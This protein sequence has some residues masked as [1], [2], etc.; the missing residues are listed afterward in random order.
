[1]DLGPNT[2]VY[3]AR[4]AWSKDGKALYVQRQS[5]DQKRLDLLA[6][7]PATG[8][9]RVVLTETSPHWVELN[10]DFKPLQNGQFLWA[11]ER[12]GNNHLYL[13]EADGRLARQVTSGDWPVGD[14]A[15]V[16]EA[17]GLVLFTA[18]KD[19]P[20]E[21]QLYSTS[22]KEPGEPKALTS[23]HGSWSVTVAERGGAFTGTYSDPATPPRTGL[24]AA[25]GSLI[26]W[27]EP[28]KLDA[29]HPYFKYLDHHRTPEFGTIKASDGQTLHYSILTPPDFD[30]TKT[31]PVVVNVYGGPNVGGLVGR[32]WESLEDQLMVDQGYVLFKLDNR[33]T[34]GRSVAFKTAIYHHLG[35]VEVED[36]LAGV[37]FLK[38]LPYVDPSRI[39]IT[40]WSYGG[41]MTLSLM[42]AK[43]TPYAVGLAGAPPTKWSLY[44]THYTEQ[45]MGTPEQNPEGYAES[46]IV[47][48]IE[49]IKPGTLLLMQGMAD[50][51]VIFENSTRVMAAL[52][53]KSIPFE[54]MDYPGERHGVHGNAKRLHLWLT[55]IGFLNRK[56]KPGG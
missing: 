40:G 51:N 47:S 52:Q 42:T 14:V 8:A 10:N 56:L 1:V 27:I 34:A 11:S 46:D 7:D 19:T 44:D 2:D 33:G 25:D 17:K 18:G 38:S 9:A 31:Y 22:Y 29:T 6:V 35:R 49:A 12:S 45:F 3:L 20:L 55:R 13:Y 30:P 4:V 43:G 21:R 32:R 15:G 24:Y 39:A 26:R 50:D 16:D 48:R 37:N 41:F 5:R 23:G 36:Q 53:A 54:V 28:N